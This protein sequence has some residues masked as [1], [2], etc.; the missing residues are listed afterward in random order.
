MDYVAWNLINEIELTFTNAD[1][2]PQSHL[3]KEKDVDG[4]GT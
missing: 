4:A 1:L 2:F 3:T